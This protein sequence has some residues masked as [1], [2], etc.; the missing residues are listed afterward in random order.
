MP[1][2]GEDAA[3]DETTQADRSE[4]AEKADDAARGIDVEAGRCHEAGDEELIDR[5]F[6]GESPGRA[7]CRVLVVD[8]RA[9]GEDV[10]DV[11]RGLGLTKAVLVEQRIVERDREEKNCESETD[12]K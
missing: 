11:D 2:A 8:D 5:R 12:E 6:E 7:Q 3:Q 9:F 1:V 10:M 4:E